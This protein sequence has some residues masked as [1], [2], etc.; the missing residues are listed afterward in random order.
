MTDFKTDN[1]FQKVS[2]R[3]SEVIKN[4][5]LLPG[6]HQQHTIETA[7]PVLNHLFMSADKGNVSVLVL[8][9]ISVKRQILIYLYYILGI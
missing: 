1:Y 3:L 2:E 4:N 6:S 9:E 7:I 8:P 5:S